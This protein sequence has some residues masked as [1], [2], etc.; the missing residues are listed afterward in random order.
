VLAQL[1]SPADRRDELAAHEAAF[2]PVPPVAPITVACT[3]RDPKG[4]YLPRRFDL[5]LPR[6][7]LPPGRDAPRFQPFDVTLDVAPN[8]PLLPT[9]A[10]LF[11]SVRHLGVPAPNVALRLQRPGGGALLGRGSSDSRGEALVVAAGIAQFGIGDGEVV[12]Q[13]EVA[14]ELVASFDPE[15]QEGEPV[16][17][18]S[19]AL[20][21]GVV[22]RTVAHTIAS[23]R[24]DT[25]RIDLP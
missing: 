25:L 16:D 8:A 4:R 23:G 18:D 12:V 17:P 9:W 1:D 3:V 19:L 2:E 11:V 21:A 20:R 5:P 22:R 15:T 24:I 7:P 6:S 10:V 14:A 13:R